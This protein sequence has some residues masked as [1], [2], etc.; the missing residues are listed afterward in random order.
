MG[1]DR[2]GGER[3]D[4]SKMKMESVGEKRRG[5]DVEKR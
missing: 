1:C 3:I 2:R 4:G 5:V